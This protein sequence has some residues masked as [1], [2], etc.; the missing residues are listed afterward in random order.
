[1]EDFKGSFVFVACERCSGLDV[2]ATDRIFPAFAC[3]T[4]LFVF[5]VVV[6]GN[7]STN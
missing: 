7:V 5:S 3:S 4:L 2:S 1:M 6:N